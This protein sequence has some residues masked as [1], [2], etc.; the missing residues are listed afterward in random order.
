M[1][2]YQGLQDLLEVEVQLVLM[3][4]V[5]L[6][7]LLVIKVLR[8]VMGRRDQ[9]VLEENQDRMEILAAQ[10][11]L[12]LQ[13]LMGSQG[14][15]EIED[16][17]GY[18][19]V[20]DCQGLEDPKEMQD[21]VEDQDQRAARVLLVTWETKVTL[22]GRE[23]KERLAYLVLLVLLAVKD[24]EANLVVKDKEDRQDPLAH[25]VFRVYPVRLVVLVV[26]DQRVNMARLVT[27]DPKET[28]DPKVI[29]VKKEA[30]DKR[31]IR[32]PMVNQ[33]I[34]EELALEVQKAH[35][36]TMEPQGHLDLLDPQAQKDSQ[37][38]QERGEIKE[39]QD[40]LERKGLM[41]YQ[42]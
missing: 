11:F 14:L 27:K 34:T 4:T 2:V 30:Q 24:Q 8:V 29:L 10:V 19:E 42:V 38:D 31:G 21:Q 33:A 20:R 41:A 22:V 25:R 40:L 7:E 18:R 5:V 13:E 37:A 15:K 39:N 23:T 6:L 32:V 36:D 28:P 17:Q 12:V 26:Q 35:L 3:D 9:M 16:F 1:M